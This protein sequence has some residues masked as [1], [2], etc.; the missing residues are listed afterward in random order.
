MADPKP[1]HIDLDARAAAPAAEGAPIHID[2]DAGREGALPYPEKTIR[3]TAEIPETS[4]VPLG[5]QLDEIVGAIPPAFARLGGA[6][7]GAPDTVARFGEGV[8]EKVL[9]KSAAGA[10]RSVNQFNPMRLGGKWLEENAVDTAAEWYS[11]NTDYGK[12]ETEA[13]ASKRDLSE[14]LL[15]DPTYLWRNLASQA[16][17][18]LLSAGAA[19]LASKGIGL[20]GQAAIP[21]L[22]QV[23]EVRDNLRQIEKESGPI[24]DFAFGAAALVGGGIGGAMELLGAK[25]LMGQLQ[26][27]APGAALKKFFANEGAEIAAESFLEGATE[28][29]QNITTNASVILA[30]K[31]PRTLGELYDT[32]TS[33]TFLAE[34]NKD[35]AESF[36]LGAAGGSLFSLGRLRQA[37]FEEKHA[38]RLR[39]EA[40]GRDPDGTWWAHEAPEKLVRGKVDPTLFHQPEATVKE[41]LR[42][43]APDMD[44]KKFEGVWRI[45]QRA[46]NVFQNMTG[47]D[48]G[49]FWGMLMA[50][51]ITGQQ[52]T[53]S[54][55]QM[56]GEQGAKTLDLRELDRY[57]TAVA[58]LEAKKEA[59]RRADLAE[60]M[61]V[62]RLDN[63]RNAKAEAGYPGPQHAEIAHYE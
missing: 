40:E 19:G 51:G 46:A 42:S 16:P 43:Q 18:M 53:V 24:D 9:G 1:I 33:P 39:W 60:D 8:L 48:V 25:G 45:G 36:V 52:P 32:I 31:P 59:Y 30:K 28:W 44:E 56:I 41:Y 21:T 29:A 7:A 47:L 61:A 49:H 37:A 11:R 57:T 50:G 62:L 54:L 6:I 13:A 38:E 12:I 27:Y 26:K 58:D 35:G 15:Y 2:L 5:Q 55:R 20:L 10:F 17:Q 34:V 14:K 22:L 3:G 63:I 23:G 4:G